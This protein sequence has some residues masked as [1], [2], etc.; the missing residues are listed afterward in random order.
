MKRPKLV[1]IAERDIS[2]FE[3]EDK[4][5]RRKPI[6]IE[7][8]YTDAVPEILLKI[9]K[10]I[11]ILREL[12]EVRNSL[13]ANVVQL[14]EVE[15]AAR[16]SNFTEMINLFN[17][18]NAVSVRFAKAR[19]VLISNPCPILPA[20]DMDEIERIIDSYLTAAKT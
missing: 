9:Q 11:P 5:V 17:E 8:A 2:A 6:T 13:P 10:S 16:E 7:K 20:D 19:G 3:G 18:F 4:I 1:D 14:D 12:R 15:D